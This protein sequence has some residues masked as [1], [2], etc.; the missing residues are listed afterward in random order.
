MKKL[1]FYS[2]CLLLTGC[3]NITETVKYGTNHS[4]SYGLQVDFSNSWLK[5]KTAIMLEEVE[6]TKIP[7]EAEI[8]SRLLQFK[9]TISKINGISDIVTSTDFDHYIFKVQFHFQSLEALNKALNQL[10]N[11]KKIVH[12]K[13]DKGQFERIA[14]YPLP[15][16]L[17]EKEDKKDDLL[18]AYIMAIYTFDTEIL[19]AQNAASK[20]SKSKKT[21]FL[22]HNVWSVLQHT[23]QMD[24]K[25]ELKTNNLTQ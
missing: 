12:F 20:I 14:A 4:G 18:K 7:N 11:Q 5:T 22:K 10:D 16:K 19:S 23:A 25:I 1:I 2:F 8:K 3:F 9:T 17:I 13:E 24:N 6:G 15:K 21:V